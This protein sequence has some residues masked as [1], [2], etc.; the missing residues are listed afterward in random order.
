[1]R[2]SFKIASIA[3]AAFLFASQAMAQIT[4]YEHEGYRGRAYTYNGPIRSISR[5]VC[6]ENGRTIESFAILSIASMTGAAIRSPERNTLLGWHP[7]KRGDQT[8]W[9]GT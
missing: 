9:R 3:G 1:M 8:A 6:I 2:L 7:P 5:R 4:F